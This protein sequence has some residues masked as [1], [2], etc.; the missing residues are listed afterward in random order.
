MIVNGPI[1]VGETRAY[2]EASNIDHHITAD[3]S[4]TRLVRVTSFPALSPVP[5]NTEPAG[6]QPH[7]R[8]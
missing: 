7:H 2:L 6:H 5:S 1:D 4:A 3:N 8:K